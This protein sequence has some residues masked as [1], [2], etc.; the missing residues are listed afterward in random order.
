M[1]IIDIQFKTNRTKSKSI[2][3]DEM[4]KELICD[5][6]SSLEK[7]FEV[8]LMK[9]GKITELTDDHRKVSSTFLKI[10]SLKLSKLAII[11]MTDSLA[12]LL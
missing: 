11:S 8:K 12:I 3:I 2:S 1:T 7:H 9:E 5:I 4:M 10:E 6:A